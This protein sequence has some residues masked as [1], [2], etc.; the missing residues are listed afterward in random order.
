MS[1]H[2][3]RIV[4]ETTRYGKLAKLESRLDALQEEEQDVKRKTLRYK[5]AVLGKV[6]DEIVNGDVS[7]IPHFYEQVVFGKDPIVENEAWK[8][9]NRLLYDLEDPDAV[10]SKKQ[11][12]RMNIVSDILHYVNWDGEGRW[13]SESILTNVPRDI[14]YA[15]MIGVIVRN[16]EP[17]DTIRE[18][19]VKYLPKDG[20]DYSYYNTMFN[21]MNFVAPDESYYWLTK[22]KI[23]CGKC[24]EFDRSELRNYPSL[25][26]DLEKTHPCLVS[27]L[28]KTRPWNLFK[29]YELVINRRQVTS[30]LLC[31][32]AKC[33]ECP[34]FLDT[35]PLDLLKIVFELAELTWSKEEKEKLRA[36]AYYYLMEK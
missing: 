34:F 16:A 24:D 25:I 15:R 9:R 19:A 21:A 17:C 30:L 18:H 31:A 29:Y 1:N 22:S 3:Q 27:D 7:W 36:R 11:K 8:I 23:A 12:D 14:S 33:G 5:A 26:S 6:C 13:P 32:R 35:F 10:F 2:K 20:L 28:E 4:D